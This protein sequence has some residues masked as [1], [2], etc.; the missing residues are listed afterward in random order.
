MEMVRF[1]IFSYVD[2]IICMNVNLCI[3][4]HAIFNNTYYFK[5]C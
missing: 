1:V 5:H 3:S 4:F 2:V